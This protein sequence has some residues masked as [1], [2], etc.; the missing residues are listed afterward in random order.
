VNDDRCDANWLIIHFANNH[1]TET[2]M[3]NSNKSGDVIS[4]NI[5]GNSGQIAVGKSITQNQVV[6]A[7]PAIV[8]EAERAQLTRI[9]TN[10]QAQVEIA[11]PPEKKEAALE[12]VGELQE[13]ITAEKPDLTTMEY[14]KKWFIKNLPTLS[15]AVT[16]VVIHP[17]VGKLVEA[18]GEMLATDFLKRFG[19]K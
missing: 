16:S 13:A 7:N 9:L 18:T 10:L 11:A 19:E 12:R 15:G 6:S 17:I 2:L 1:P 5:A 3:S 8:T 14:V 4:A